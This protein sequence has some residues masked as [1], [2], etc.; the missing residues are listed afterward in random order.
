MDHSK[1]VDEIVARVAA[2]L[3]A[4]ERCDACGGC[5]GEEKPGLLILTQQHG[6]VCHA[7]LESAKLREHFR[8][9]CALLKDY[10]VGIDDFDVVILYQLTNEALGKLASG[11][12]DTPYTK[13]AHEAILKGK[14]IY[15]PTEQVELYGYATTA[16]APY[17]HM[18]QE[19]LDLLVSSGVV[20]C[21]Q[22]NL[23]SAI[24]SRASAAP[25]APCSACVSA[26][27][28]PCREEREVR[29]DKRVLT[30]RDISAA[31]A[32]KATAIHIGA[33]CI[34]TDLAKDF[35]KAKG[36]ALVRD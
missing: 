17:Y 32:D 14:R 33:R 22:S 8:T 7:A 28:S 30:E 31:C 13:L 10:Q 15:V 34:L 24:L 21:A 36:I 11:V 3:A 9:D 12:C 27:A 19:K 6:E 20:I 2:K 4:A 23:E 18:M 26:P 29:I 25:E 1:L 5:S 16:P 35:A